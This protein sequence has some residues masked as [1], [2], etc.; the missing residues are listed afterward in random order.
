MGVPHGVCVGLGAN[1]RPQS[2]VEL[3][4]E[5]LSGVTHPVPKEHHLLASWA[6]AAGKACMLQLSRPTRKA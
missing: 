4:T 3:R 6:V 5:L 1:A 2:C